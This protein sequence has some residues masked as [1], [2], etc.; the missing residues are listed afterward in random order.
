MCVCVCVC[1]FFPNLESSSSFNAYSCQKQL[2]AEFCADM[3]KHTWRE[4]ARS[5]RRRR[6]A[7]KKSLLLLLLLHRLHEHELCAG[8]AEKNAEALRRSLDVRLRY[9]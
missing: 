9:L 8:L 7:E 5:Y 3:H 6:W 1:A 2:M 4:T